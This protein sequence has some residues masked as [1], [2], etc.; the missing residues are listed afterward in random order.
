MSKEPLDHPLLTIEEAF[1]IPGRGLLLVPDLPVPWDGRFEAFAAPARLSR[2][3]AAD[4]E[5][6][7][8]FALAH[9]NIPETADI[10]RRWRIVATL[11]DLA[12]GD[13]APGDRLFV[14]ETTR[15]RLSAAPLEPQ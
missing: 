12:A 2:A 8:S 7:A 6:R 3:G 5:T 1:A 15:A 4:R 11:P 10:D 9:L 14:A 13:A